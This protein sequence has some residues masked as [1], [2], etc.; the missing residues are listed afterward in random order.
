MFFNVLKSLLI[1]VLISSSLS[2]LCSSTVLEF[3][4][5]FIIFTIIQVICYN[6]YNKI[7]NFFFEKLKN[8]RIKEF[9]KQG[10][11]LSCPCYLNKKMFIPI[12]LGADNSF[13]C[14]ECD[15]NVS[16]EVNAK[17]FLKTEMIDL[18]EAGN[19]IIK[20]YKDIQEKVD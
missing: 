11:E 20:A 12:Q 9:S 5:Y 15:K 16:V 13:K 1:T 2:L 19:E 8:E 14:L 18:D 10:I 17:T 4:K 3:F 6:L 7:D